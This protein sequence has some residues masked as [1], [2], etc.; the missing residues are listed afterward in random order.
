MT[1]NLP[2]MEAV[3]ASIMP[4]FP[5]FRTPG[6][7]KC[8]PGGTVTATSTILSNVGRQNWNAGSQRHNLSL[9]PWLWVT[10]SLGAHSPGNFML[11]LRESGSLMPLHCEQT[12]FTTR[13][14]P[15]HQPTNH[16]ASQLVHFPLI[17]INRELLQV[18][19]TQKT[20][21]L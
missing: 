18:W 3:G 12:A 10:S 21:T 15:V 5:Y 14:A 20:A 19:F 7:S 4:P 6:T 1:V 8:L 13:S 11:W 16:S 17:N 9:Q 2:C